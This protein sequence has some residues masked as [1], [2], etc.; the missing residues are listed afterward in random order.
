VVSHIF[1]VYHCEED[2][3]KEDDYGNE[4]CGKGDYGNEEKMV[5][6]A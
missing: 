5:T 2:C 3:G 4:G 6:I 1:C